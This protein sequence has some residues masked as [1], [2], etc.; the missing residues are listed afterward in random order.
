MTEPRALYM[1]IKC[2]PAQEPFFNIIFLFILWEFHTDIRCIVIICSF[3]FFLDLLYLLPTPTDFQLYSFLF[4]YFI[5]FYFI[6]FIYSL[7]MYTRLKF[8]EIH[9]PSNG[10]IKGLRHIQLLFVLYFCIIGLTESNLCCPY[11]HG[12]EA[13]NWACDYKGPYL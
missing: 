5:L 10:G 1:F 13:I 4:Y 3:H 11:R 9:L 2:S 6:L 12:S 8:T 7:T